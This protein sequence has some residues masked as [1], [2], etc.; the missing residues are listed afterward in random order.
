MSHQWPSG[1]ALKIGRREDTLERLPLTALSAELGPIFGQLAFILQP[2][3]QYFDLNST[4]E[5]L[6][7]GLINESLD[8]AYLMHSVCWKSIYDLVGYSQKQS[9]KIIS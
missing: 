5:L 6:F 7:V 2:T 4:I 8:N 9:E 1:S 3:N